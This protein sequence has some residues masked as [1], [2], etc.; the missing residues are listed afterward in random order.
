M[1]ILF[2]A[3]PGSIHDIKW[4]SYASSLPENKC[5]CISRDADKVFLGKGEFA[6][7]QQKDIHFAGYLPDF[8]IMRPWQTLSG[9]LELK[10]IIKKHQIDVFH[11]LYAEPNALWVWGKRVLDIPVIIT[12]RGSDILITIQNTFQSNSIINRIVKKIYRSAFKN[13]DYITCTSKAQINNVK[14][15]TGRKI[16]IELL[17]TG[18]D[19]ETIA[20]SQENMIPE[21]V[22]GKKYIFFP[23]NMRPVYNHQ[24]ALE[25]IKKLPVSIKE[26]FFFVF[27][28]SDS[29]DLNYLNIIKEKMS[30]LNCSKFIFLPTLSQKDVFAL[31]GGATMVVMTPISDGS[32][33]SAMEAM[34]CGSIVVLPSINY[35]KDLFNENTCKFYRPNDSSNLSKVMM[36]LINN[37][38]EKARLIENARIIMQKE[39]DS[40]IAKT[41]INEIYFKILKKQSN[42]PS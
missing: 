36:E 25:A 34:A 35:D 19:L 30:Q 41:R 18:L 6:E 26:E 11:I 9:Y 31:Y 10:R 5:I 3:H 15:L 28:N 8:S 16:C 2:L 12:T 27:L 7:L 20:S 40:I 24:F 42:L 32:P 4:M 13:A 21:S 1:N 17:R 14:T 29:Q 38:H 33:V 22:D 37:D 39:A 23:R